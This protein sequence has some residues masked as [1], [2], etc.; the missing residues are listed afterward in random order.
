[1][2]W[3]NFGI[4]TVLYLSALVLKLLIR[5]SL[6]FTFA[7]INM[8]YILVIFVPIMKNILMFADFK[9]Q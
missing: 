6:N 8:K 7:A 1:M 2:P 4:V 5:G 9:S 3:T